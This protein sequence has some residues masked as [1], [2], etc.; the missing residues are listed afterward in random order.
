MSLYRCCFAD[1]F[2]WLN[3]YGKSEVCSN[4]APKWKSDVLLLYIL[5]SMKCGTLVLT[6]LQ[7]I[8]SSLTWQGLRKVVGNL[9]RVWVWHWVR[10]R[11]R[12]QTLVWMFQCWSCIQFS[13]YTRVSKGRTKRVDQVVPRKGSPA[14]GTL[15]TPRGIYKCQGCT[16]VWGGWLFP[17]QFPLSEAGRADSW[18]RL[19]VIEQLPKKLPFTCHNTGVVSWICLCLLGFCFVWNVHPHK[20]DRWSALCG[21][22][23][24]DTCLFIVS[25]ET[26]GVKRVALALVGVNVYTLQGRQSSTFGSEYCCEDLIAFC[27]KS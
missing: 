4:S 16:D 21:Q 11:Q 2:V 27:D 5:L 25:T 26:K 9:V 7:T 20:W 8:F 13:H 18:P 1:V 3:F 12:L 24:W 14:G 23:Y 6:T 17:W 22:K 19:R 15:W 10:L